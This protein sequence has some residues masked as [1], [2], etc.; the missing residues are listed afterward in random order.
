M[1]RQIK[2]GGKC[3]ERSVLVRKIYMDCPLCDS[4]HEV[5]ERTRTT[6]IIIK[7]EKVVYQERYYLCTNVDE[8]E[9]EFQTASLMNENLMLARNNYRAM[10]NLLTSDE[11]VGIR[12]CYGLTQVELA[13][14]LGWGEATISR[15]ESK[16]IQDEAYDNILRI[17][18]NEPLKAIEFLD[19]NKDKFLP[20]KRVQIRNKMIERLGAYG[21]EFISRQA[22]ASEYA[23]YPDPVDENGYNKL[24]ID[25]IESIISYYA[26]KVN[27]LYKVKLMKM[28]WY[29][30][31]ISYKI[32]GKSM[33][34]LV[35]LR[36]AMGALPIGH[37]KLMDLDN[38]NVVEELG[39]ESV[40]YHFY[41][42]NELRKD[43][44]TEE[45]ISILDKVIFKFKEYNAADI[46]D[47]MHAEEA[48][49]ET[50]PGQIILY[51]VAKKIK[52]F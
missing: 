31:A 10:H 29:A 42:N 9:C 17:V 20:T 6:T 21:K 27:N 2:L 37:Y 49:H 15:Y 47:Y 28:L 41:P 39:Y 36:E 44:L 50:E 14:L 43:I 26:E 40:K 35:Y 3:M 1:L 30:D 33:T 12:E 5:E 48:Y 13:K 52:E 46:V 34:G 32:H 11:I 19:K 23:M 18:K 51:S 4:V 8:E 24:D 45:E 38:V 22:L 16:A 25:K 7:G